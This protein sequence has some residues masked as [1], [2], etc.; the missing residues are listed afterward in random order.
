MEYLEQSKTIFQ[1]Q[2]ELI[3]TKVDNSMNK[4]IAQVITQ[5]ASIRQDIVDLRH[6]MHQEMSE[7]RHEM[8]SRLAVVEHALGV[9]LEKRTEI[10]NR[11]IDYSFKASGLLLTAMVSGIVSF[12]VT[13]LQLV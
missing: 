11:F 9:R 5:I 7:L 1:L 10:R 12:A 6:E 3:D 2:T 8:G 4:A 13:H